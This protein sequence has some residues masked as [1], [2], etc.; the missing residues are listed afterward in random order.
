MT[1]EDL[2]RF[3][4]RRVFFEILPA[5]GEPL[6]GEGKIVALDP[7]SISIDT[8]SGPGAK[9]PASGV[10]THPLAEVVSIQPS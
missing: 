6:L 1:F 2:R 3:H 10:I 4:D 9:Q 8:E 5:G 7:E